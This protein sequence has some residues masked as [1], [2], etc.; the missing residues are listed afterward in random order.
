MPSLDLGILF[1]FGICILGGLTAG[2]FFRRLH[3]PQVVGYIAIGLLVGQSG[4]NIVSQSDILSLK[5]FT[6]FALGIIGFL[7]GGELKSENFKK[8][9]RQFTSILLGEGIGAFIIVGL[10]VGLIVWFVSGSITASLAGGIVFGAIASATDPA[11]TIDVLWEYRSL[12]ILT[13]SLTA[14]VALDDALAMMLYGLGIGIAGIIAGSSNSMLSGIEKVSVELFGALLLGAVFVLILNYVLRRV[15]QPEKSLAC[16]IGSILLLISIAVYFDMDVILAT[17]ML[18]FGLTNIA[19]RKSNELFKLAKAF[20][21]PIYILFFVLVGARMGIT[22][23]PVWLWGI[24]AVYIIGR[25]TGKIFGAYIGASISRSKLVV[26]RYLGLGLLSQGGVAIGLSIMA[27]QRLGDILLVEGITLAD[28]IIFGV[29]AT[30]LILQIIGPPM[31][32]FAVKLADEIGR[33]ITKDDIID[34]WCAKDVM[35]TDFATVPENAPLQQIIEKLTTSEQ[36]IYP[37]VDF[38]NNMVGWVSLDELKN[39]LVDQDSWRW[40]LTA[41]VMKSVDHTTFA[42]TPLRKVI[43]HMHEYN[44]TQLPVFK[45]NNG[46]VPIGII[47]NISM[48]HKIDREIIIKRQPVPVAVKTGPREELSITN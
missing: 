47:D 34:S 19:P 28:A 43:N 20:S 45:E 14:I 24:A 6:F 40:L 7:V 17:M 1:I 31:T 4:L 5:P 37:V 46:L 16:A 12:G 29:A 2:G 21:I 23:M 9:G 38:D 22:Y 13:T 35:D 8:Y 33:N 42:G 26:R 11:S 27:S 36:S 44:L 41:D 39:V 25:T 10:L 30:T 48:Q 18:G 15:H 32:K 3:I